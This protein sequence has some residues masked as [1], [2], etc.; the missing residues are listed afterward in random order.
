MLKS[1]ESNKTIVN[2]V[3]ITEENITNVLELIKKYDNYKISEILKTPAGKILHIAIRHNKQEMS[4]APIGSSVIFLNNDD[5]YACPKDVFENKYQS[6]EED[7]VATFDIGFA[8]R[9]MKGGQLVA[10]KNWNAKGQCVGYQ[11]GYGDVGCNDNHANAWGISKGTK[12][13][14][15]PWLQ[16]KTADG[17][18]STWSPSV[19]DTLADDWYIVKKVEIKK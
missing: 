16:L 13:I 3:V 11:K 17:S 10:R 7:N 18:Y 2:A 4:L 12:I 1:Y 15:R 19:S 9:A 14:V 8:I 5:I 6:I